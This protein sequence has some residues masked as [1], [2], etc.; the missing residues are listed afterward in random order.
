MA[1][2]FFFW[3][4]GITAR[5]RIS[6]SILKDSAFVPYGY[7]YTSFVYLFSLSLSPPLPPLSLF[8][9]RLVGKEKREEMQ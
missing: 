6:R 8:F 9:M 4:L 2:L 5:N 1:F 3:L 7:T